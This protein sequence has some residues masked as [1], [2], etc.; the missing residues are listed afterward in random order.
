MN[1]TRIFILAIA[2]G[3][4]ITAYIIWKLQK[5]RGTDTYQKSQ[6][7]IIKLLKWEEQMVLKFQTTLLGLFSNKK[8]QGRL[9]RLLK[10]QKSIAI[11]IQKKI[12]GVIGASGIKDQSR[13]SLNPDKQFRLFFTAIVLIV[14]GQY[15]MG[16][17][18]PIDSWQTVIQTINNWLRVDAKYLGNVMLGMACTLIG[19]ILFAVSS[20]KSDIFKKDH[21]NFFPEP[22]DSILQ[23]FYFSRWGMRFLIGC[24][25]F[26]LL[27]YRSSKV[28]L[29]FFDSIL[30]IFSI[31]WF[32]SAVF[33]Y[34]KAAGISFKPTQY[35]RDL[36]II[37]LLL[38]LGLLIGTYQLQDI[39]NSFLGDEG[40]F[41]ETARSIAQGDYKESI[42]G[43]G[44]YSY[45]ILSSYI[46]AGIIRVFGA[47]LWGWRFASVLPAM[48]TIIP[49][50][51]I[52]RDLFNRWVGIIASLAF[53]S[54]PFL[55]SFARL[56]YN[57]SQTIFL[58]TLCIWFF[59]HGL[60]KK[61]L[62]FIYLGGITAGFGFLT[63]TSGRLG[64]LILFILFV[65][66]YL[67]TIRYKKG[68][69]FILVA[70]LLF[71]LGWAIIATP[72]LVYGNQQ[73]S[74]TLRYKM[75][76][77][78]FF[79]KDYAM[80]LLGE[81]AITETSTLLYLDRF[82]VF[83]NPKLY[84]RLLLRGLVRSILG[85]QIDD[86]SSNHFLSSAFAGPIA[87]IFYISGVYAILAHFWRKNSFPI[88]IW[89]ATGLFFLSIISTYPP[90]PAHLVPVIPALALMIGIGVYISV[91]QITAY[92]SNKNWEWAPFRSILLLLIC[93]AIMIAGITEYYIN[94]PKNYQPNLEQ[95][96]NWA[97]L[98]NPQ[99]TEFIYINEDAERDTW[100]PY[101][102]HLGLT[103]PQFETVNSNEVLHGKVQWPL[104]QNYS[105]FIE[106]PQAETLA[107][108]I[109]RELG[110]AKFKTFTDRDG[111][112]VGRAI[113][114]GSVNLSTSVTFL[115][116]LG[117]LLIS[118]VMWLIW[119]LVG[120]ALYLVYKT[121]PGLRFR[122]LRA[123]TIKGTEKLKDR[124]F[125]P[126]L[127]KSS[128][129]D[130]E[131]YQI[132]S[133]EAVPP[134]PANSFELG[135]F[136]RLGLR[137][138]NRY[139]QAKIVFNHQKNDHHLPPQEGKKNTDG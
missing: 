72:H 116:G 64:L 26:A 14:L 42:I 1:P 6:R 125:F 110:Q 16:R 133:A 99:E 80:G 105:I 13:L 84:G 132:L 12:G 57:N 65:Y 44:V 40:N 32:S 62:F 11:K 2:I 24:L 66:T 47:D 127:Q 103:T 130:A 77:G 83:Y 34:D 91:N 8:N 108:I 58:V 98:H 121:Y 117:N 41:F 51:L 20:Y 31:G 112:P 81:E 30:W 136:I 135:F 9:D 100:V 43:F 123:G 114:K 88:L 79:Q 139:F 111:N 63:Y 55:L 115:T 129:R 29:E 60:Q 15:I 90:R 120:L 74:E 48:L 92:L 21:F 17:S 5:F 138:A 53:I 54:S 38:I 36:G 78:L 19:G 86:F 109:L 45:P 119:P 128:T 27:I 85:F 56:G 97:G 71:I 52:G 118:K 23:K 70:I 33:R 124:T 96:M 89:F 106:E 102:Y 76:E 75:V 93:A 18:A 59:Y 22:A 95:V 82:Q 35:F 107:P 50:Y 134:E 4:V 37:I 69:R 113:V 126:K 94:S 28:E 10:Y 87:V 122:T 101:F 61:S 131:S 67:S 7:G 46:Q 68:K 73:D 3:V 137:K 104:A 39:P 49:L 25:L